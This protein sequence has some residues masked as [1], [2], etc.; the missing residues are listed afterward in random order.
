MTQDAGF[1]VSPHLD[2]PPPSLLVAEPS[3]IAHV[4]RPDPLDTGFL[5]LAGVLAP[6][7]PRVRLP[8][9]DD[10]GEEILV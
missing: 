7:P 8:H 4:D 9:E 1:V 2:A 10:E 5:L 6:L 3:H